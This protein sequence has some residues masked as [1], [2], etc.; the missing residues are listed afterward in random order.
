MCDLVQAAI[1]TCG[2][3]THKFF[4]DE[5]FSTTKPAS[6]YLKNEPLCIYYTDEADSR[7]YWD[8]LQ[9]V[10]TKHERFTVETEEHLTKLIERL[11]PVHTVIDDNITVYK[12][13]VS[14]KVGGTTLDIPYAKFKTTVEAVAALQR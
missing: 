2:R 5:L 10:S 13:R 12:D 11:M 6:L 8:K 9:H 14:I 3:Q 4:K 1:N 7:I